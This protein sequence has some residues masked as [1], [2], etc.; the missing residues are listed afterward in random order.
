MLNQ[1]EKKEI[2][3]DVGSMMGNF[4]NPRVVALTLGIQ[5]NDNIADLGCGGGYFT[6][7]L[8]HLVGKGG[9][10]Y[11]VDVMEGPLEAVKSRVH[12]EKLENVSIIR[13]NL[14]KKN[15]LQKEIPS[16]H[17]QW[18]ILAS[19]LYSSTKSNAILAESKRIL[20]KN[21][22]L[23]IIDWEK[24]PKKQF[25]FFGPPLESRISEGEI[26]NLAKKEGF[27]LEKKFN[28]GK[29]HYGF[30]FSK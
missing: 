3:P 20:A 8:A 12:M 30:I 28:V 21:G 14:E 15:A 2:K 13:N 26:K 25:S 5:M 18:V 22:K 27:R 19:I 16:E 17:C 11:A 6:I 9:K 24:K 23:V 29:F 4:M 10:V 7:P 1:K